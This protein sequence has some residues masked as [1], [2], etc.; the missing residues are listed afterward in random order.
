MLELVHL[1]LCDPVEVPS[2]GGSRY[3]VTFVDDASRKVVVFFLERKSQVLE[4]LQKFKNTAERQSGMKLKVLRTDNGT[5]YV[6]KAFRQVLEREAIR[7]QTSCPYTPEPNCV[8]ERM[9]HRPPLFLPMM[10]TITAMKMTISKT[11]LIS[12]VEVNNKQIT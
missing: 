1:D 2:L 12:R 7:H 4:A 3:F 6:N 10:T 8:A 5:E 11:L 9:N